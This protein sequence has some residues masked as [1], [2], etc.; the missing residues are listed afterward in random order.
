MATT[1]AQIRQAKQRDKEW[2]PAD[3]GG[4]YLIIRPKEARLREDQ[5]AR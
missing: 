4:L 2:K 5:A 3:A 1:D